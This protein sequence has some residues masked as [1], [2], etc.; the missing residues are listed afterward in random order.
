MHGRR[1]EAH[2]RGGIVAL[3]LLSCVV[4]AIAAFAAATV[5]LH[6]PG[7]HFVQI[8]TAVTS[9]VL[10]Y[11]VCEISL[12]QGTGNVTW[13]GVGEVLAALLPFL[14][15]VAVAALGY[16][17]V[18]A[19]ILAWL[20]GASLT[21]AIQLGAALRRSLA[22]GGGLTLALGWLWRSRAIALSNGAL[23]LCARIDVLVVSIVISVSA[24]GIYSIP[25]PSPP[26][27]CC[28]RAH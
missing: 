3:G 16:T 20:A 24:A 6:L 5:G 11:V 17:S 25:S 21:A 15:S 12:A 19:L 10:V 14:A 27:C 1:D 2:V 8:A 4:L 7:A 18:G 13:V 23:Q 28:S 9:G 26:T 22:L